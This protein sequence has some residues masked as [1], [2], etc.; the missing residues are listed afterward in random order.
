LKNSEIHKKQD[1]NGSGGFN[2]DVE[3]W[4]EEVNVEIT[5]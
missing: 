2:V 5:I 1:I 3:D 4:H